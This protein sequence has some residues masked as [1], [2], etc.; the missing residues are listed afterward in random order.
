MSIVHIG[1]EL[2]LTYCS[3][4]EEIPMFTTQYEIDHAN[5]RRDAL[6]RE[7]KLRHLIREAQSDPA[8]MRER[9]LA[10]LGDLMITSGQKLK[11]RYEQVNACPPAPEP[12]LHC[13]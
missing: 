13:V 5:Q 2:P 9:W 6:M 3:D 11:A 7:A 1:Q 4:E 10:M 12:S 8:M